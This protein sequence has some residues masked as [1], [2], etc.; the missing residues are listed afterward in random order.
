[1]ERKPLCTLVD[2]DLANKIRLV[3]LA[4]NTR[5]NVVIEQAFREYTEKELEHIDEIA[6][7]LPLWVADDV[8]E[9]LYK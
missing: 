2:Q 6:D 1:M 9:S 5:N 7:L 4:R 8:I 3:A